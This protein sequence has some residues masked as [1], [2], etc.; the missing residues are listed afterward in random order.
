MTVV[1]YKTFK[2]ISMRFFLVAVVFFFC[3]TSISYAKHPRNCV[4][5]QN[6]S[7]PYISDAMSQGA[8]AATTDHYSK[9]IMVIDQSLL[10]QFPPIVREFWLAHLCGHEVVPEW[11]SSETYAD[12]YAIKTLLWRGR[13]KDAMEVENFFSALIGLPG[14]ARSK[15]RPNAQR[16]QAMRECLERL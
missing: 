9:P 16:L 8:G 4:S 2:G 13:L 1:S 15:H 11:Q 14:G 5:N 10:N 3:F 7:V 12:C 6:T